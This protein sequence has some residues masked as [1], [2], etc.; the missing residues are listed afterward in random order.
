MR[1]RSGAPE[2]GIVSEAL[3]LWPLGLAFL[4]KISSLDG[5]RRTVVVPVAER[6]PPLRASSCFPAL[7]ELRTRPYQIFVTEPFGQVAFPYRLGY[8]TE[9][10][11]HQADLTV[12]RAAF[13][14]P[15]SLP[16]HPKAADWFRCAQPGPYRGRP[17][18]E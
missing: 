18:L 1:P 2:V 3:S 14:Q 7:P 6:A 17:N 13:G 10:F 15:L 9:R 12:T 16:H 11:G 5:P 8:L 4:P